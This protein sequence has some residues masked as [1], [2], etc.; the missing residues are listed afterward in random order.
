VDRLVDTDWLAV[1][2]VVGVGL[3]DVEETLGPNLVGV[4][5]SLAGETVEVALCAGVGRRLPVV[6]VVLG[7]LGV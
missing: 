6:P 4:W 5:S 1:V 3:I 7:R 2:V